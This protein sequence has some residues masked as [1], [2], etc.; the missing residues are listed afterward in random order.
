MSKNYKKNKKKVLDKAVPAHRL[1]RA[2]AVMLMIFTL[3]IGR[4]RMD[5]VCSRCRT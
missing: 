2:T 4:I 3:L 5:T 1:K